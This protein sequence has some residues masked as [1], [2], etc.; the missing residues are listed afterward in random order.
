MSCRRSG[1]VPTKDHQ[2]EQA[3][4]F[5]N[6]AEGNGTAF[7]DPHSYAA[8][9][10]TPRKKSHGGG[11][12]DNDW[13]EEMQEP[14]HMAQGGNPFG[15]P[16]MGYGF[17]SIN[18]IQFNDPINTKAWSG[19]QID[20][21]T[22]FLTNMMHQ[23]RGGHIPHIPHETASMPEQA[24]IVQRANRFA[25]GGP[26]YGTP[27][28]MGTHDEPLKDKE[29]RK[30]DAPW[31]LS[32]GKTL[33]HMLKSMD[34]IQRTRELEREQAYGDSPLAYSAPP[35][36]GGGMSRDTFESKHGASGSVTLSKQE[37][38]IAKLA[39]ISPQ[40]YARNKL[41]LQRRKKVTPGDF[42]EG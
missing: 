16:P 7:G 36:R 25:D 17:G 27:S 20:P 39:G 19:S 8:S 5:Y 13:K 11:M 22:T 33:N 28:M 37:V 18:P 4:K 42:P 34:A 29:T 15:V 2:V 12:G 31:T 23:A 3:T 40:Q 14:V 24:S 10:L 6:D 1:Y 35:T 38:E 21:Q 9:H 41:E 32:D 26:A 30:E